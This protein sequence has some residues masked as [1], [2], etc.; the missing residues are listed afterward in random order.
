MWQRWCLSSAL[1]TSVL[2]AFA[3]ANWRESGPDGKMRDEWGEFT[4]KFAHP[5]SI[6]RSM[7]V[8]LTLH[9]I[10]QYFLT[11]FPAFSF[12]LAICSSGKCS[13]VARSKWSTS[14]FLSSL[15]ATFVILPLYCQDIARDVASFELKIFPLLWLLCATL[16][17]FLVPSI[18]AA[19]QP[20]GACAIL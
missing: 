8:L 10:Y 14:L 1:P 6:N 7:V 20:Q 12:L 2:M 13:S 9:A 19:E 4:P 11:F 5:L 17:H 16:L 15:F 18:I 3:D